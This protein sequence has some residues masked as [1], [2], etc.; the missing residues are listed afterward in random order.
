MI[1]L[2]FIFVFYLFSCLCKQQFLWFLSSKWS[3]F[4][5]MKA[6]DFYMLIYILLSYLIF[7]SFEIFLSLI[8]QVYYHIIWKWRWL[9]L[10]DYSYLNTLADTSKAM[11]NSIENII[12]MHTYYMCII[13][14]YI[15][16]YYIVLSMLRKDSFSVFFIIFIQNGCWIV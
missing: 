16:I 5:C 6:I 12:H 10:C 11:L 8:P 14:I 9:Y 13:H 7:S 3:L 2:L 15:Y 1:S 4:V